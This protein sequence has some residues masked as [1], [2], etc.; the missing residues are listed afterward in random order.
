MVTL[1]NR[2]PAKPPRRGRG[3]HHGKVLTRRKL[4]HKSVTK[5]FERELILSPNTANVC[6]YLAT[7]I[8]I[9][10]KRAANYWLSSKRANR[11]LI[12]QA[13]FR[14]QWSV[15]QIVL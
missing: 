2:Q 11:P 8:P 13:N 9:G 14:G 12:R 15:G 5:P 7:H 4:K 1:R 10:W 3:L 6:R